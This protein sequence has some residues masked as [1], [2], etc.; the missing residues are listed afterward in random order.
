MRSNA[1]NSATVLLLMLS[2]LMQACATPSPPS[3]PVQPPQIPAPPPS[4]MKPA[5][6]AS[7]S[8]RARKNIEQWQQTLTGSLTK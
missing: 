8:E 6:P 2:A 4:L 7:Y 5:P 1:K 3:M